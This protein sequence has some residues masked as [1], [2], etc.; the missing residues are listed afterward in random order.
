M[1]AA[2]SLA[3]AVAA[4]RRPAGQPA[5]PQPPSLPA[6]ELALAGANLATVTRLGVAQALV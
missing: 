3:A 2:A 5:P 1:D 4:H 6:D